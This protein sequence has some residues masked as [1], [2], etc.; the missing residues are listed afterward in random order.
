MVRIVARLFE[1]GGVK[2]RHKRRHVENENTKRVVDLELE[3]IPV[4]VVEHQLD[5]GALGDDVVEPARVVVVCEDLVIERLGLRIGDR[6]EVDVVKIGKGGELVAIDAGRAGV[7]EVVLGLAPPDRERHPGSPGRER[8]DA[9]KIAAA[10]QAGQVHALA[11]RGF[12]IT[13]QTVE[14]PKMIVG[15]DGRDPVEYRLEPAVRRRVARSLPPGRAR[16][17]KNQGPAAASG[18]T[19]YAVPGSS[20]SNS[21]ASPRNPPA[22]YPTSEAT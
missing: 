5:V 22:R 10:P 7:V 12:Q 8:M 6:V 19:H 11:A 14:W 13:W 20:P 21:F 15:I 18:N 16:R 2:S 4:W 9:G 3:P 1:L 17:E